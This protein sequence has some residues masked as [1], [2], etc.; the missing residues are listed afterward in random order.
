MNTSLAAFGNPLAQKHLDA[1]TQG[2]SCQR[3]QL[4]PWK[5]TQLQPERSFYASQDGGVVWH[6]K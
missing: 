6:M 5:E 3:L 4:L 2:H 1:G